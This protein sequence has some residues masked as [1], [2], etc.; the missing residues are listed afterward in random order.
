MSTA[1]L[2]TMFS[3]SYE[4][5]EDSKHALILLSSDGT[6]QTVS[7][8]ASQLLD[9]SA[10]I[11]TNLLSFHEEH[12]PGSSQSDLVEFLE[13]RS[14]RINIQCSL[15]DGPSVL[16]LE[17]LVNSSDRILCSLTTTHNEVL[18][19]DSKGCVKSISEFP[20][21]LPL[22]FEAYGIGVF[23]IGLNDGSFY[24]SKQYD[25]INQVDFQGESAPDLDATLNCYLEPY[26]TQIKASIQE[27][28]ET[29]KPFAIKAAVKTFKGEHKWL[30]VVCSALSTDN[31]VHTVYGAISDVTSDYLRTQDL[32][33]TLER[34]EKMVT[35]MRRTDSALRAE[36]EEGRVA[37]ELAKVGF[38]TFDCTTNSFHYNK[39]AQEIHGI[40]DPVKTLEEMVSKTL[41][42]QQGEFTHAI[43]DC[44]NHGTEIYIEEKRFTFDEPP[45][46]I[47]VAK[48]GK[49]FEVDENGKV[50][51]IK[52]SIQDITTFVKA[53]EDAEMSTKTKSVFLSNVSH[54]LRT[55]LQ[56]I[57]GI[58]GLIQ[59]SPE[60]SSE[61]RKFSNMALTSSQFLLGLINN[62]IDISRFEHLQFALEITAFDI[63]SIMDDIV[64]IVDS[65]QDTPVPKFEFVT[66]MD[67]DTNLR[68]LGDKSRIMQ[69]LQNIL[70]L[71]YKVTT[72]VFIE[73][74]VLGLTT[75][76]HSITV[77]FQ[78][79]DTGAERAEDMLLINSPF[80]D[81]WELLHQFTETKLNLALSVILAKAM[82][83]SLVA[84]RIEG[85]TSI[86]FDLVL[87]IDS[88]TGPT[89][90]YPCTAAVIWKPSYSQRALIRQLRALNYCVYKLDPTNPEAITSRLTS[91]RFGGGELKLIIVHGQFIRMP[92]ISALSVLH[93]SIVISLSSV[94]IDTYAAAGYLKLPLQPGELFFKVLARVHFPVEQERTWL[95]PPANSGRFSV[96]FADDV[97]INRKVVGTL[98]RSLGANV[99]L[100]EDGDEV[101]DAYKRDPKQFDLILLDYR[102]VRMSGTEAA[103]KIRQFEKEQGLDPITMI[104]VTAD[105]SLES[106]TESFE[107][108]INFWL[109]KPVTKKQLQSV[110]ERYLPFYTRTKA[111]VFE[112]HYGETGSHSHTGIG[113]I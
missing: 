43:N 58:L 80:V 109:T 84:K 48:R 79:T 68:V 96:C 10:L 74:S 99:T 14:S 2:S 15:L 38:F 66:F 25:V 20:K 13:N 11:G 71:A 90:H 95:R 42:R 1:P 17:A 67:P 54:N 87:P 89:V 86:H 113:R 52:G 72:E 9:N 101:V 45:R 12:C 104:T 34:E 91:G 56:S 78:L 31:Q 83:S 77:R 44:I 16:T 93:K 103:K 7:H 59:E 64:T 94:K 37:Q 5:I 35:E 60:V 51:K 82:N 4:S 55:P 36:L 69:I 28:I 30:S 98:L 22:T 107:A 100:L 41:I 33:Q 24:W 97:E 111:V 62:I 50:L 57:I 18:L 40:T 112:Q 92:L 76:E 106:K 49:P 88:S 6:I 110:L 105:A 65:Q 32:K 39:I 29:G 46:V 81:I 102:M 3:C 108:G 23:V 8:S 85:V 47:C 26:K 53:R 75:V 19:R 21:L 73:L 70:T 61:Y 63:V 27:T